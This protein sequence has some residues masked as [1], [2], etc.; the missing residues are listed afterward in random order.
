MSTTFT[1]IVSFISFALIVL[2]FFGTI[3]FIIFIMPK[4]IRNYLGKR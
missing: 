3:Y 2:A 1:L 4:M